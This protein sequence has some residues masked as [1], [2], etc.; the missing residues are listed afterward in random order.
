VT[1]IQTALAECLEAL[2]RGQNELKA[3]LEGYADALKAAR[4]KEM[5]ARRWQNR[6]LKKL[7]TA[8]P[9]PFR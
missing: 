1:L 9:A 8:P 6:I 2:A 3:C 4:A 5:P 7:L